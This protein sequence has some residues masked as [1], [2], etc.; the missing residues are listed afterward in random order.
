LVDL[1]QPT[2]LALTGGTV[3]PPIFEV[4]ALLGR[5]E[6]LARL[7]RALDAVPR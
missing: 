1:A 4:L 3:S 6:A 2:R 5:A 7:G